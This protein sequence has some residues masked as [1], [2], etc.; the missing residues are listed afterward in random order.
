MSIK[1]N[2]D[3]REDTCGGKFSCQPHADGTDKG[4]P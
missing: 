2:F 4:R 3:N 1:Q